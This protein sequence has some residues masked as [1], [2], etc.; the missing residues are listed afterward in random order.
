MKFLAL[1][2]WL[3]LLAGCA[4]LSEEECLAG[5]WGGIGQRDG[6]AGLVAETQFARHVKAC[7]DTGVTP[8]RAAWQAGYARGLQ[9][10]CTPLGG[11]KEGLDGRGYRNVCPA[12]SEAAF[13]RGF[14]IGQDDYKAREDVRR[15]Q[16]KIASLRARNAEIVGLI[17]AEDSGLQAELQNNQAELLR[18]QLELGFVRAQAARTRRA[19]AEFRAG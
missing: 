3:A 15:V 19:V 1:V 2:A 4:S 11:L 16:S 6:A 7:A 8:A 10:Y 18:L 13:L 17:T 9:S 14:Q 12:A 5:D